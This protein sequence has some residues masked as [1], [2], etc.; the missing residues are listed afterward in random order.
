MGRCTFGMDAMGKP[1]YGRIDDD[2]GAL[3]TMGVEHYEIHE[4]EAFSH[5]YT[6]SLAANASAM[7]Y[8]RTGAKETHFRIT[9]IATSGP[10]FWVKLY[11]N[12]ANACGY[13]ASAVVGVSRNRV[14]VGTSNLYDITASANGYTLSGATKLDQHYVGGGTGVGASKSGGTNAADEE[15]LLAPNTQYGLMYVSTSADN[16][17]NVRTFWYAE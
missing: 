3:S 13:S 11:E 12:T 1:A 7:W 15:F 5:F 4:G 9:G 14:D 16:V 10:G 17:V 8:F 6:A 2:T